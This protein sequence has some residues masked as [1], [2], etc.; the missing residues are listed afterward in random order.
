MSFKGNSSGRMLLPFGLDYSDV[1]SQSNSTEKPLYELPVHGPLSPHEEE[2]AR[3]SLAFSRLMY[4]GPFYTGSA[5]AE[6]TAQPEP[7]QRYSDRFKKVKKVGRSVDEYPY[8][9]E[10]FPEELFSVM[11]ITK[12]KKKLLLSSY[13]ADGGVKQFDVDENGDTALSM[14]EKL[15]NLAEDLDAN[16]N[17]EQNNDEEAEEDVDDNFDEDEEDDDDYNAEKYFEDGDDDV[18][19]DGDDEAA[20]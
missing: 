17:H 7:I 14:L 4:D 20:F 19:D 12:Q 10:F 3:Q 9:L 16:P 11:G 15:R 13:R 2:V 5:K 1:L 8:Q 6:R 18:G